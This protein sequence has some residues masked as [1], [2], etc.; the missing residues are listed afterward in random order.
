MSA[1]KGSADSRTPNRQAREEGWERIWGKKKESTTEYTDYTD[2]TKDFYA[3]NVDKC[4]RCFGMFPEVLYCN[5]G[6]GI[7]SNQSV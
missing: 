4:P 6:R 2:K 3:G 5:C 1:G 7:R